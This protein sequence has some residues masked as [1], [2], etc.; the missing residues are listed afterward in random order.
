MLKLCDLLRS[1]LGARLLLLWLLSLYLRLQILLVVSFLQTE[2]GVPEVISSKSISLL[3]LGLPF[4][5]F[6]RENLSPAA[7]PGLFHC[8]Y[9][10]TFVNL[11]LSEGEGRALSYALINPQF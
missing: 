11:V 7:V 9:N 2:V 6:S 5:L 3:D 8:Y 10:L 1:C 4:V